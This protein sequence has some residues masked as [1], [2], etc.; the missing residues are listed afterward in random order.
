MTILNL[1]YLVI[2]IVAII[3]TLWFRHQVVLPAKPHWWRRG[4]FIAAAVVV[5]WGTWATSTSVDGLITGGFLCGMF[6]VFALWRRGLTQ[7]SIINGLGSVRQYRNLTAIQLQQLGTG[8]V[9][10]AMVGD[11]TV[12]RMQFAASAE[13]LAAFLREHWEAERVIMVR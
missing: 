9:V 10:Q 1:V 12:I 3:V 5:G 13:T 8:C 11:V 2:L 6:L 7:D 4:L